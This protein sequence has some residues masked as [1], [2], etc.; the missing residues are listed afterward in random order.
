MKRSLQEVVELVIF[1]LV[2]LLIGTGLLWV[3]GWLFSLGGLLLKAVAG[4]L[5]LLLR[6][7]VPVALVA[8]LFY[9]IVKALR[10]RSEG[11]QGA[12]AAG[13]AGGPDSGG[14]ESGAPGKAQQEPPPAVEAAGQGPGNLEAPQGRE[15]GP[16]EDAG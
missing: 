9:F 5:W 2:A 13:S 6:F 7:V 12:P 3:V 10:Q 8:G 15:P 14:A 1:G 4:L 16:S 11:S